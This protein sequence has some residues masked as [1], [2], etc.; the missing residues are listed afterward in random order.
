MAE[1]SQHTANLPFRASVSAEGDAMAVPDGALA[2]LLDPSCWGGARTIAQDSPKSDAKPH[3]DWLR[4]TQANDMSDTCR[5]GVASTLFDDRSAHAIRPEPNG[6][7]RPK[8]EESV[9]VANM[10]IGTVS[11]DGG[12]AMT[13]PD[14]MFPALPDPSCAGASRTIAPVMPGCDA[15]TRVDSG[16]KALEGEA[17]GFGRDSG[18]AILIGGQPTRAIRPA[19]NE[20]V[21]LNG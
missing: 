6:G 15:K 1:A 19:P 11:A 13:L 12:N 17:V 21:T 9:R 20:G 14:G 4:K 8:A 3:V 5:S 7:S 16:R 18:G 2:V 10:P